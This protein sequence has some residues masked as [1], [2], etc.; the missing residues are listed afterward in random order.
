MAPI[1]RRVFLKSGAALLGV[2]ALSVA[3]GTKLRMRR[4]PASTSARQPAR[5]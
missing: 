4:Q 3:C 5:R 2:G 1:S